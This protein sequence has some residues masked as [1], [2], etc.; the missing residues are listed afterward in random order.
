LD[1]H[2][3]TGVKPAPATF[4]TIS[5]PLARPEMFPDTPRIASAQE[6]ESEPPSEMTLLPISTL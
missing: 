5:A 4:A 6:P 3:E 1:P 2:V